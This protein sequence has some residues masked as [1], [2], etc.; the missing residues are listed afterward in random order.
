MQ[1]ILSQGAGVL[2]CCFANYFCLFLRGKKYINSLRVTK[3]N[4]V[5]FLWS[6]LVGHWHHLV[7]KVMYG[8]LC[9]QMLFAVYWS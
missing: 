4:I 8:S 9:H 3:Q 5:E 1:Q 7:I 2:L 6:V